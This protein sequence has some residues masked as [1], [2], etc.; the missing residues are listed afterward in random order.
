MKK[1]AT[2][3]VAVL[4]LSLIALAQQ[5][6][7]VIVLK[8]INDSPFG[9]GSSSTVDGSSLLL[10]SPD[11]EYTKAAQD[12]HV[13]GTVMLEGTLGVE[14]CV[15]NI[16]VVRPL[17]YGLDESATYAVE[18]WRWTAFKKDGVPTS[19]RV[20]IE[21][22]FSPVWSVVKSSLPPLKCGYK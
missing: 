8:P 16:T 7:S 11:P 4:L 2:L 18:R 14:G 15:G 17:G 13:R 21:V 22:D 6:A 12:G 5:H 1:A 20:Q 10:Y 3:T 9:W 19:V